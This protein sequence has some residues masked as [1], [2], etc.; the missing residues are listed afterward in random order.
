M[1]CTMVCLTPVLIAGWPVVVSCLTG[2]AAA[3]GFSTVQSDEE[4]NRQETAVGN[5]VEVELEGSQVLEGFT[6]REEVFV[7]EGI[8]F[9]FSA[10][11]DGRLVLCAQG[12]FS[13][14]E[15]G[16]KARQFAGK[17][18]QAYSYHK[19]VSQ[20]KQSGFIISQEQVQ[21][22]QQIHMTLRRY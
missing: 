11:R 15:L 21:A 17:L 18:L 9:I 10:N 14:E 22:D 16:Q 6:G 8:T 7:K 13:K 4:E 19:A 1:P 3:L 12:D 20:L 5:Q 2:V